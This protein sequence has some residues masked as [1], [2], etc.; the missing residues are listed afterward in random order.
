M[1]ENCALQ[2]KKNSASNENNSTFYILNSFLF[3]LILLLGIIGN[4]WG[5]CS[6][7]GTDYGTLNVSGWTVGQS[8]N[9]ATNIYAG[10]RSNI[11]NTVQGAVY[12]VSSCG[13]SY[14]SQIT[15]YTSDCATMLGYNDDNGPSCSGNT[16]SVNFT[17]TGG[18]VWAKLNLYN[19]LTNSTNTT[20][21]VTLISLP[22][23]TINA[24]T[25]SLSS[26]SACANTS[27]AS[28]SFTVSGTN[29][30]SPI[31]ISAPAGF[32][33]SLNNSTWASSV[34]VGA[35]GTIA[36]N[37]VYAIMTS[38]ASSPN[39]GNISITSTNA[40]T[41]TISVS[42]IVNTKPTMGTLTVN[43]NS[44][45]GD[46]ITVCPGQTIAVGQS[47]FNNQGGTTYFYSDN[48]TG[49]GGWAVAPDWEIMSY[50]SITAA[51]QVAGQTGVNNSASFSY[52]INSPGVYILHANA[53]IN[54]CYGD[55]TNRYITVSTPAGD[56]A[57]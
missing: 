57:T 27:S 49:F 2:N 51:N 44:N 16:A 13:A 3:T 42:G 29:M 55:G 28:Q 23:P 40:T 20:V 7:A 56:P 19:C 14:D 17:G 18:N 50:G 32:Q 5:Q 8:A 36:S 10:E 54:S 41:R 38:L 45:S 4:G 52:K 24:S 12:R 30:Q 9:I 31:L 1:K 15:I 33:V 11:Q 6:C 35:A 25:A 53:N 21:S 34:S 48:T 46:M 37:T 43:G 22:T 47:G 39:A 26:F